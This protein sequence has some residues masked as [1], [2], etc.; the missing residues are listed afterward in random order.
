MNFIKCFNHFINKVTLVFKCTFTRFYCS[1][2]RHR[3]R[4]SCHCTVFPNQTLSRDTCNNHTRSSHFTANTPFDST[5][6]DP[7][8]LDPIGDSVGG[9]LLH[10]QICSSVYL[11]LHLLNFSNFHDSIFPPRLFY[12]SFFNSIEKPNNVKEIESAT[13]MPELFR[14]NLHLFIHHYCVCKPSSN[15]IRLILYSLSFFYI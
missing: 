10:R 13:F 11:H 2:H 6:P 14:S 7:L 15:L 1:S 4:M 5:R 9:F 8:K 12:S 3:Q